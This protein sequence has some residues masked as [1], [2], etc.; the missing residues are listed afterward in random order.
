MGCRCEVYRSTVCKETRGGGTYI[1]HKA[2]KLRSEAEWWA[3][4]MI[5]D[6]STIYSL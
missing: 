3:L 1:W 4:R 2:Y 5:H 6:Q